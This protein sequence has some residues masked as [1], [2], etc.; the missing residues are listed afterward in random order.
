MSQDI[1][2]LDANG[3]CRQQHDADLP[4]RPADQRAEPRRVSAGSTM[5]DSQ[6]ARRMPHADS[7]HAGSRHSPGGKKPTVPQ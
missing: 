3:T 2:L 5:G 6:Y 4:V 1:D 7:G